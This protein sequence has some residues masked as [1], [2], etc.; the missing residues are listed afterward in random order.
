MKNGGKANSKK[1]NSKN[2]NIILITLDSLRTDHLSCMGYNRNTTSHMDNL[3]KKD[4]MFT[5]AVSKEK[6]NLCELE[7]GW[8]KEFNS[9]IRKHILMEE[10]TRYLGIEKEKIV[11]IAKE[12]K[13]S[14]K[15]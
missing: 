11:K 13:G 9:E 1:G 4:V 7:K 3:A 10:K 6:E 15:L 5:D 12:I 8:C 2:I 14:E